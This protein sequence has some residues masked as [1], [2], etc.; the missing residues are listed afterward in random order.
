MIKN[1]LSLIEKK[2][3]NKSFQINESD[4]IKRLDLSEF[5][6]RTKFNIFFIILLQFLIII[7]FRNIFISLFFCPVFC[8]F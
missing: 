1:K 4:V 3:L 7:P 2:E 8:F 5:Q 6:K